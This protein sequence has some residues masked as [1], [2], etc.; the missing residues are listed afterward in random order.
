MKSNM[1]RSH[2]QALVAPRIVALIGVSNDPKK[3]TAR[4]LQ[5]CTQHKFTG[6]L[7]LVNP[8][9]DQVLGHTAYPSV[10]AIPEQVDHAYIMLGTDMVEAALDDCIAAGVP[11]VSVLA[12]GFAEAGEMGR[13]RQAR[14]VAKANAAGVMLIGPNSMG[15]ANTENGFICTTNAAFKAEQLPRGRLAV[16]SHSGS[17]IGTLVSRG[18]ARNIGFSKLISLGNEAQSCVGS[19]G[20]ALVDD[21]SIDGFVLFLETLRNRETFAA[22]AAAAKGLGKPVVAYMLGK[23]REGQA[24]AVSHTGAMTGEAAAISAFLAHHNI[25]EVEQFDA[26]FEAPALLYKKPQFSQRPRRATVVTTTGGGG[27]MVVDQLC[28]RGVEVAGLSADAQRFFQAHNIPHGSGKLVDVTLAGAQYDVM[29]AAISQLIS[30]PWSGLIVVA[31]G[32]SAQFNPELAVKPIIDAV[33]DM[34]T[35]APVVA[36]PLPIARESMA[37]L[38]AAHIPC[39]STV[40]S[41]ADSISLFL[42]GGTDNTGQTSHSNTDQKAVEKALHHVTSKK[43][44]GVA[45][46]LLNEVDSHSIFSAI[47]MTGP[48]QSFIPSHDDLHEIAPQRATDDGLRY[49]LVAKLVSSDLPHKSEHGAIMLDIA[50]AAELSLAVA[51][52]LETTKMSAPHAH[53]DG[54]L[55][56]EM[57]S[58]LGEA[59]IGLR[60]DNL[61]GPI[62]TVGAGGIFAEIYQ[63]VSHRPTPVNIETA[64]QMIAEVKGFASLRGYRGRPEGDLEALAQSIE[65]FS[66]LGQYKQIAE[67]EINPILVCET[68]V[69]MLDALI[70]LAPQT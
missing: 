12:D 15:V 24:L 48:R 70:R 25:A 3:L 23:S 16:L 28:L 45:D 18:A 66:Q 36:F 47:G 53:I 58:G 57:V 68:G 37:M 26:L 6:R 35:G 1:P 43:Q 51:K 9:R 31:I 14:L 5:F 65:A 46:G 10:S 54:V 61:V 59:L 49:P 63:D 21:P 42:S 56:Q 33:Q 62:I 64:R 7:Y 55:L 11:V 27:A 20:S 41:C 17:L 32:S 29:K 22:F 39:F 13:D 19:V 40:E 38:E 2:S 60:Q 34:P 50:D 30:D 4:P 44:S 69:V 67:A 8:R 52:M